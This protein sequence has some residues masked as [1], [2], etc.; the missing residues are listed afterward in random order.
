MARHEGVDRAFTRFDQDASGG[1]DASELHRALNELGVPLGAENAAALLAKYDTDGS[2]VLECARPHPRSHHAN[3]ASFWGQ[4]T[5]TAGVLAI[6]A[7]GE[8]L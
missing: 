2:G 7:P 6:F 4:P 1:I 5:L 3:Q 8:T